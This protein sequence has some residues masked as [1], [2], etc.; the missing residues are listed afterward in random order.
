MTSTYTSLHESLSHAMQAC[1]PCHAAY[2]ECSPGYG[3]FSGLRGHSVGL[4]PAYYSPKWCSLAPLS[5]DSTSWCRLSKHCSD[6]AEILLN[7][8]HSAWVL[9][10]GN[11]GNKSLLGPSTTKKLFPLELRIMLYSLI[12]FTTRREWWLK[13]C[14]LCC[15]NF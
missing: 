10:P 14:F 15:P 7:P 8:S 6:G 1:I 3:W 12:Y 13:M 9:R 4:C 11:D 2:F 5:C